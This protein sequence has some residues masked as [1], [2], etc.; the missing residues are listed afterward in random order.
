[1]NPAPEPDGR[2]EGYGK[3]PEAAQP[4]RS[5]NPAIQE[6]E[7]RRC[8]LCQ[9]RHPSFGFGPPLTR[10]GQLVWACGAHQTA[11]ARTLRLAFAPG[12]TDHANLL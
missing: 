5:E 4:T 11:V 3:S 9:C 7:A 12:K 2:W 1:M 8:Q 10:P 6:Y